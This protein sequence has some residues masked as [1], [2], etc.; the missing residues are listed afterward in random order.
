LAIDRVKSKTKQNLANRF[1]NMRF[2]RVGL[3]P[4]AGSFQ[5]F[6]EGYKDADHWLRRFDTDEPLNEH[7][8]RQFLNQFQRLVVLDYIIRN[9]DRGNDNWLIKFEKMKKSKDDEALFNKL[10]DL[11]PSSMTTN[12]ENKVKVIYEEDQMV[13]NESAASVAAEREEIVSNIYIAAIDNGLAFPYKHPDEWR[14]CK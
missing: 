13:A 6:V 5:L 2:D 4:K 10:I 9:T 8:Q 14:A 3:P 11:L 7:Q 1:P 12:T